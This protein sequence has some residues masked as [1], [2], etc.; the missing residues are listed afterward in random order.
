MRSK[1]RLRSAQTACIGVFLACSVPGIGVRCSAQIKTNIVAGTASSDQTP[2]VESR[3]SEDQISEI[4]LNSPPFPSSDWSYGGSP[5][6]GTPDGDSCALLKQFGIP[7][8]RHHIYG[9][10]AMGVDASTSAK[11]T[12]PVSYSIY[13]NRF[14]LNQAVLN[15]ERIPDTVQT[16]K[17]DW[18]YH[19]MALYGT[20]YRFTTSE[21][22]FSQ[23]L[24]QKNHQYGFDPMLAYVDL[25]LPVKKGMNIRIGRFMSMP[26]IESQPSL[27]NYNMTHSLAYTAAPSTETGAVAS[28]KLT[29][30]WI[31][32]LGITAG[33]D[34]APWTDD[35]QAS[36]L[37]CL[38]Y[39]TSSHRDNLY[40]CASGINGGEYGHDNVQHYDAT[41][42]H[43]FNA[44][45][46][47]ASEAWYMYQLDVPNV[48]G[49]VANPVSTKIGANGAYCANGQLTCTAPAYAFVNYLNRQ[50]SP[51][52]FVGFRSDILN[53][54]R[55]QRTGIPGKYTENTIYVT[56]YLTSALMLRP[57]L[58]FDHSWDQRGYDNGTARN[59]IFFGADLIYKF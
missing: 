10:L 20:D 1:S 55:G 12:Y 15:F 2:A 41:W 29:K 19:V 57:E 37:A 4:P 50:V 27:N 14:E 33:H 45:W 25:Y 5:A 39:S 30:Q 35:A 52:L 58:R 53:D 51:K 26:G 16:K 17:F 56:Q 36:A 13:A 32:Q 18:G 28:M 49:N 24:Y 23:Q 3:K 11:S 59:Q 38:D 40:L 42:Y 31:V 47:M 54:K 22:Y 7:E 9:W 48:A 21:G 46:H 44:K 8:G 43:R 6:I 34:V